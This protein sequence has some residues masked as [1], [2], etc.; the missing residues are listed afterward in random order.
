MPTF[1]VNAAERLRSDGTAGLP[2]GGRSG[3]LRGELCAG[4]DGAV[5]A[6]RGKGG[7]GG[8]GGER[9]APPRSSASCGVG[10]QHCENFKLPSLGPL[11]PRFSRNPQLSVKAT[12]SARIS[13]IS[14]A[15]KLP[16]N[17]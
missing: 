10:T 14:R 9:A 12:A 5:T 17:L 8:E 6:A 1:H 13:E 2:V 3:H 15:V 4:G 7:E 16:A 11:R